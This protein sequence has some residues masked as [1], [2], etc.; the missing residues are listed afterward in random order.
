VS[1]L[2]ERLIERGKTSGRADDK[3]EFF[4]TR[5]KNHTTKAQPILDYFKNR[6][7]MSIVD[8]NKSIQ[9]TIDEILSIVNQ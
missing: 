9:E 4:G 8:T 7:I 6:G 1:V 2:K 5:M 3:I